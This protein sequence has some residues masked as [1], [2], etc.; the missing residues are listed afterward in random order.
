MPT[1]QAP[2]NL[3]PMVLALAAAALWGLSDFGGGL[4]GR[5]APILGVLIATQ[6][7]GF[8]IATFGAI[9][10][11]E[12][13]LTG[14]DLGLSIL[15]AGLA[16]IGV[17]SLYG[18]LAVG[19]MGVVAPVTAVLTAVTPALIGIALQGAPSLLVILG[20]G[21]AVISVVVVSAVPG[22][23]SG[24]PSGLSYALVGGVTLGLLGV[25]LSRVDLSHL[26]AP[27]M[28]MRALEV[29]A[30]IIF[31][32]LRRAPWR[33]PRSTVGLVLAVGLIDVTGNA[34]FLTASRTGDLSVAAVL[35]S[36]YPVVTVILA[37]TILRER[38]K[39]VHAVG[40]ALA[41]TAIAMITVGAR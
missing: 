9:A 41:L 15:A 29:I 26:F 40:V 39:P 17:A 5:R 33:M 34:A 6:G 20:F 12:P 22:D 25:V 19:R 7:V 18:G 37:G 31:V 4:L 11:R 3:L 30:F 23:A 24:R 8:V 21:V 16:T 32:V 13:L 27:L 35:S 36:L 28:V 1:I 2:P 38:L 10:T 14:Q